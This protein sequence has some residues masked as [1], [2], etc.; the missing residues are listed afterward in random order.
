MGFLA[1]GLAAS[2]IAALDVSCNALKNGGTWRLGRAYQAAGNTSLTSLNISGRCQYHHLHV[3]PAPACCCAVPD[4]S[5]VLHDVHGGAANKIVVGVGASQRSSVLTP[6]L[7]HLPALTSL[8]V[9]GASRWSRMH[10]M[11]ITPHGGA[12]SFEG[13]HIRA[14]APSMRVCVVHTRW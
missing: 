9:A 7:A 8:N 10:A 3:A 14:D 13:C 11:H 1:D 2:R 5:P 6:F 12:G 4:L